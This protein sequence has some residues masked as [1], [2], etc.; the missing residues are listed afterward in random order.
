METSVPD[1]AATR[2][3]GPPDAAATRSADGHP[4]MPAGDAGSGP[5]PASIGRFVVREWLGS[6]AFGD[7][8]RAHDPMLDREV[9][10][11]VAKPGSLYS[12]ERVARFRRE[13]KAVA[14]LRH[15]HVVPLYETGGDGSERFLVMAFVS[16][17]TLAATIR[18]GKREWEPIS[19]RV[20][21]AITRKLAEALAYAHAQ[22]VVHRDVKPANVL[23]DDR[24]E[25]HLVDFGLAARTE[26]GDEQLT[27]EGTFMGTPAYMAPEQAD[28]EAGPKSDQYS[29]GCTLYEMLTGR[30]PF[31]GRPG[32]QVL[33]HR[34]E[35][36][37]DPREW[38][39]RIPRDLETVLRKCLEKDPGRRYPSCETLAEDLARYEAGEPVRARRVGVFERLGR[40]VRRNPVVTLC[41][42]LTF[43]SL[44]TA[45]LLALHRART[46]EAEL[47]GET[48]A[49]DSAALRATEYETRAAAANQRAERA[50]TQLR[51]TQPDRPARPERYE[52]PLALVRLREMA[53]GKLRA[54]IDGKGDMTCVAVTPDGLRVVTGHGDG[55]ARVWNVETSTLHVTLKGHTAALWGVAIASDGSRVSTA[56]HDGTSRLWDAQTAKELNIWKTSP[57]AK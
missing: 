39:P 40:W 15:P 48:V 18:E 17:Q 21:A 53:T 23:I 12:P 34:L 41:L 7:V 57:P 47:A 8:Y 54:E 43:C 38:R 49:K 5:L 56:S 19:F 50:E 24:G 2:T 20:A 3:A 36:I 6:G 55:T 52:S 46:A 13:A 22:G 9:A 26:L 44:L 14:N 30:T 16:G 27:R 25:P 51:F 1:N 37:S 32:Q 29:L 4:L 28:G 45:T 31:A 35:P 42:I 11:K 33:L 10:L